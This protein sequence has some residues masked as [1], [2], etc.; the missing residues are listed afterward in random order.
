MIW[1]WLKPLP[2]SGEIEALRRPNPSRHVATANGGRRKIHVQGSDTSHHEESKRKFPPL[3]DSILTE[4]N[5]DDTPTIQGSGTP[6]VNRT[7]VGRF[8]ATGQI[9]GVVRAEGAHGGTAP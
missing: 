4:K 2:E 8:G 9:S 6:S 1:L 7:V 3:L 5:S